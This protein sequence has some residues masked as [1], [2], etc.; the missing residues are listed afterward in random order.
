MKKPWSISTTVRNPDRI[1]GFLDVAKDFEGVEFNEEQQIKFQISLIMRKL[2]KPMNLDEKMLKYYDSPSDMTY[3][4]AEEIFNFMRKKSKEL[5]K[6]PGL[7][8]R[9]SIAPLSKMGLLVSK[10]TVSKMYLTNFG[11]KFLKDD[12]DVGE[13]FLE[14]F[15]KW[16]LPNPDNKDFSEKNGFNIRPFI[17]TLHII[18]QVNEEWIKLGEKPKGISKE[19][20]SIFVPTTIYFKDIPQTVQEIINL[21]K[22]LNG[23]DKKEEKEIKKNFFTEKI[24][25]FFEDPEGKH[26]DINL[27]NLKDYGDN[28]IRYFKITRFFYIRGGGFYIDIEPRRQVEINSLLSYSNGES[29]KFKDMGEY[30]E[31]MDSDIE[32]PWETPNK[33]KGI[34]GELMTNIIGLNKSLVEPMKLE[35]RIVERDVSKLE[36]P[37]LKE[38]I[39]EL[40]ILRKNIQE[41]KNHLDLIKAENFEEIIKELEGIHGSDKS[42]SVYLEYLT[43]MCLHAINDA[44]KIQPNYPVG[45]DN[46]PTFTAPANVPDIECIY[47]SFNMICEVTMLT[48]RDQWIN[49]GQPVMRHLRDFEIKNNDNSFCLFIAPKIH[50]DT[51]NTFNISNKYEYEGEKQRIIPLSITQFLKILQRVLKKK[52]E[53]KP[54]THTEFKELFERLYGIAVDSKDVDDWARKS[55]SIL[56]KFEQEGILA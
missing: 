16:T 27:G 12:F 38:F 33:L 45:D 53:D 7:R 50:R 44:L 9:V 26:L 39:N 20:F 19:E 24:N 48:A 3:K 21:R 49:E 1:R 17:A 28:I 10:K 22:K 11:K 56:D 35:S 42:H 31:Y 23:K 34:A 36:V 37:V 30:L 4:Q 15:F 18:N 43:T 25:R 47:K 13:I 51:F 41:Y 32:Y 14:Y 29:L 52:V 6:D 54:I 5:D 2:Y 8:G 46:K 55:N 40:R